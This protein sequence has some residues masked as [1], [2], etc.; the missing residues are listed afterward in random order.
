MKER[1]A[2]LKEIQKIQLDILKDVSSFCERNNIKYFLFGGTLL[3]AVRHNGFIPWDDDID[4]AMLREDYEI[5]INTYVSEQCFLLSEKND[6][7][8]IPFSKICKNGTR[9]IE[10]S[11]TYNMCQ[12]NITIG[13]HIDLFP[14]DY[15][16][17]TSRSILKK[18]RFLIN[19]LVQKVIEAGNGTKRIKRMLSKALLLPFSAKRISSEITR[20]AKKSTTKAGKYCTVLVWGSHTVV[21]RN[22]FEKTKQFEFED[23]TLTGPIG[24]DQWL[25]ARYGD[26]MTLPPVNQRK[27]NHDRED[28]IV[29]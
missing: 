15:L 25:S 4:I 14:I 2:S 12:E 13:I 16:D 7:Y 29:E 3:G 8:A 21:N 28:Y 23:I 6:L 19:S 11:A 9:S 24:W 20:I 17:S 22:V 10:H 26:Y 27:A 1:K 18:E 5:F